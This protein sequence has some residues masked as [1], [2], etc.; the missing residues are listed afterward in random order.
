ML[1]RVL[2]KSLYLLFGVGYLAVGVMVLLLGTPLLPPAVRGAIVEAAESNPQTL[3]IM[4]EFASLLVFAGLITLWFV[5]RYDDSRAFHWAMTAFWGLLALIHWFD[6][7]GTF[8]AGVGEVVTTV[9]FA[10]FLL[11]GLLRLWAEGYNKGQVAHPAQ[12][13]VERWPTAIS[14]SPN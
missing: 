8:H 6:I 4:Q 7:E 10:V 1:T 12:P 9:P 14:R 3:H 2:A 5:W 13:Q 11:V